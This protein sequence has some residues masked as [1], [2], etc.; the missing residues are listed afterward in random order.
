MSKFDNFLLLF[1]Y[2]SVEIEDVNVHGIR[3]SSG[4]SEG[5]N[6]AIIVQSF[7][8]L[9]GSER[10]S[11]SHNVLGDGQ[12][13]FEVNRAFIPL[14]KSV[15]GSFGGEKLVSEFGFEASDKGADLGY[16]SFDAG[17][18]KEILEDGDV[19]FDGLVLFKIFEES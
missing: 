2:V 12:A 18:I 9:G 4:F 14:I 17:S 15:W 7:D 16:V 10:S 8:V 5:R 6:G 19:V 3:V 13:V 11:L 1:F